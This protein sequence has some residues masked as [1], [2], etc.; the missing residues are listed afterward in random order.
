MHNPKG[1]AQE[2]ALDRCNITCINSGSMTRQATRDGDSDSAIDLTIASLSIAPRCKWQTLGKH[3]NDHYP[4]TVWIKRQKVQRKPRRKK[5]FRYD[6]KDESPINKV[7]QKA[8]R[9]PPRQGQQ[10]HQ[11]QQQPPWFTPDVKKL[12]EDKRSAQKRAS[13][14]RSCVQLKE[15]ARAAAKAFENAAKVV[16]AQLYE[17]FSQQVSEDKSLYKFWQL[18]ASM[19]R[20]KKQGE[21]QDFRREDD[22]WVRTDEEKGTALFERYL[23]QTD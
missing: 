19:N 7:R 13:R 10:L 17:E 23:E 14:N 16:K 20:A 21:M 8:N 22:Q 11:Q 15:E 2:D 9:R 4:C 12:W 6:Y 18:Y 5:A 3:S 1:E